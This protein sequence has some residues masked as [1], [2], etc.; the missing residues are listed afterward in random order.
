MGIDSFF[1]KSNLDKMLYSSQT[2][3]EYGYSIDII[4]K[5]NALNTLSSRIYNENIIWQRNTD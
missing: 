3:T 1:M 4:F 5:Q 2:D